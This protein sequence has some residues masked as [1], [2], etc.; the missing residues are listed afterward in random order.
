MKLFEAL[1]KI[2]ECERI[3]LP[4]LSSV[5][6]FDIIIEIGYAQELGRPLTI[7]QLYLLRISSPT[8]VRRKL[9][10]LIERGIVIRRKHASD[11]RTMVLTVSTGSHRMLNKYGS[12]LTEIISGL[13]T[14]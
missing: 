14:K 13:S 4:F 6:D 2:R 3:Q 12:A 7:K 11:Q 5:I 1:K 8:T 9:A 10:R